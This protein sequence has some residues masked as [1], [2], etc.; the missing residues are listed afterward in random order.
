MERELTDMESLRES[1]IEL[2]ACKKRLSKVESELG[3]QRELVEQLNQAKEFLV[4]NNS[5]LLTNVIKIQLFVESIGL[6]QTEIE[7][8]TKIKDNEEAIER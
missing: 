6:D 1:K 5:K 2:G 4:E 7:S 8:L 3:E